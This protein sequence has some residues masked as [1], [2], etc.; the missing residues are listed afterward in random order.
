PRGNARARVGLLPGTIPRAATDVVPAASGRTLAAA[1]K[2][3]EETRA[4]ASFPTGAR[5][6]VRV[7]LGSDEIRGA[8]VIGVLPGTDPALADEAVVIGAHYDHLGR[9]DGVIYPGAD[10]NASGAATVVALARAFRAAGRPRR[11][12]VFA[13]FGAEELGL[14]GSG[15]HPTQPPLPPP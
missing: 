12:L 5:A 14:I 13:L 8:N 7:D 11:T 3:L 2:A 4:P 10:D 6:H 15:P 9:V 1:M